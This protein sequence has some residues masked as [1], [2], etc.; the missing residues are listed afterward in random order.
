[1]KYLVILFVLFPM[2]AFGQVSSS[3]KNPGPGNSNYTAG[4]NTG[5][6][7]PDLNANPNPNVAPNCI[8]KQMNCSC[9]V[10]GIIIVLLVINIILTW[11][12]YRRKS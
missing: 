9:V 5:P 2:I 1:M 7:N 3:E 6:G 4:I 11:K 8:L 10:A 12:I